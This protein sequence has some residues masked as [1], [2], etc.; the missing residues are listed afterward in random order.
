VQQHDA[1][2]SAALLDHRYCLLLD[3][4]G[5]WLG[6]SPK[7]TQT[8]LSSVVN[9]TIN[10]T[11]NPLSVKSVASRTSG[12]ALRRPGAGPCRGRSVRR[13][14]RRSREEAC[15]LR[16]AYLVYPPRNCQRIGT[17]WRVGRSDN[18]W[19]SGDGV[20]GL[21]DPARLHIAHSG[22]AA[23]MNL[24]SSRPGTSLSLGRGRPYPS[25]HGDSRRSPPGYAGLLRSG[26]LSPGDS[27]SAGQPPR[28]THRAR[29][30]PPRP[31]PGRNGLCGR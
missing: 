12:C 14:R 3:V 5:E 7:L 10:A 9:C 27:S 16:T 13:A 29:P 23:V 2:P 15:Y 22:V 6:L 20:R 11:G 28:R 8:V 18:S 21:A 30:R 1:L 26:R 31:G 4:C 24:T 19:F 17:L 25:A